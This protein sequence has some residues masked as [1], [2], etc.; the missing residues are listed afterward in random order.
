MH[1]QTRKK[2]T[3]TCWWHAKPI[4][5]CHISHRLTLSFAYAHISTRS[6][7]SAVCIDL[8]FTGIWGNLAEEEGN[9]LLT[10]NWPCTLATEAGYVKEIHQLWKADVC[11]FDLHYD[12]VSRW[13][14]LTQS[15]PASPTPLYTIYVCVCMFV[16]V[17]GEHL[18]SHK[19]ALR[20][21]FSTPPSITLQKIVCDW[22]C[23]K[24]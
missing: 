8:F 23:I 22:K 13:V 18:I 24:I 20:T 5:N 1:T 2:R 14:Q 17:F 3:V 19:P 15:F 12:Q 9:N 16:C 7:N 10:I 4:L 11:Q 21:H 6:C